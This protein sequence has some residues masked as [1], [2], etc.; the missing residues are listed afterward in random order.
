MLIY[1]E[2]F[3]TDYTEVILDLY[4]FGNAKSPRLDHIRPLKDARLDDRNGVKYI[5]A[6][7]NGISVFS[8]FDP[9]KKNTWKIPKG[10]PLPEGITLV[11]DKRLGHENH[12]M[13]APTITMRLS[14][15]LDLLDQ[16]KER[17]IKVS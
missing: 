17:A 5:I 12:Y 13:L 8:T 3:M 2:I 10:T 6:D 11:E 1:E 4:R 15:F 16:I 9:K 14:T 7:G